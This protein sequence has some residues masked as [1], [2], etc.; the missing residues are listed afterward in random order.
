[1]PDADHP[2]EPIASAPAARGDNSEAPIDVLRVF[3]AIAEHAFFASVI[4]DSEGNFRYVNRYFAEMCGYAPE[5]MIGQSIALVHTP[6]QLAG[7]R[8]IM[9]AAAERGS[10]EPEEHWYLR[11]DGTKFPLLVGCVTVASRDGTATYTAMS[12]F[13]ITPIRRAEMA[14]QTLFDEMLDGFAHHQIICDDAGTPIDYRY[15]AANP[16]FETMT[17]LNAADL[18]GRTVRQALPGTEQ[19]WIENFGRVATTGVPARFEDYSGVLDKHFEVTAFSPAEGEFACIFQ[20]ITERK[21]AEEALRL[22][23]RELLRTQR[24]ARLG[25]WKW[26]SATDE[27]EWT[28]TLYELFGLDPA[29]PPPT[30]AQ[31]KAVFAPASYGA[32]MAAVA[33][34]V[35]T[36][37][38]YEMEV[39]IVR[40]DGEAGWSWVYGERVMDSTGQPTGLWGAA[41]D[42]TERKRE[43]EERVNLEAQLTRSRN[44]E[45]VGT[46][47]GGIAHD[48]NN[49]LTVILGHAERLLAD[50][51]RDDPA[52]AALDE[53]RLATER[54]A[55][56]T[57]QLLAF[58][59]NQPATPRVIDLNAAVD[60][61]LTMLRRLIGEDI[62]LVWKAGA[63]PSFVKVDPSQVDQIL[64]NL[65][66]NSRDAIDGIG[67]ITVEVDE[68]T[69]DDAYCL[70]HPDSRP[71]EYVQLSVTDTGSG[72]DTETL[73]R[74]F[75]PFFTTKEFGRG[76]GLGLATVY[77]IVRQNEGFV[78]VYSEPGAGT[79]FKIYLPRC[80]EA[81]AEI[82]EPAKVPAEG[83]AHETILLVEDEPAILTMAARMLEGRGY[84]V[85]AAGTPSE[86]IALAEAHPDAIDLLLTDV[87]L[88]EMNG[89][90]LADLLRA[91]RPDLPCLFMS[92]YTANVMNGNGLLAEGA[93]FISKPF[94]L[95]DLAAKVRETLDG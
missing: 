74:L 29:S 42:I 39:E 76:T 84:S 11:R 86:A 72:M 26:D 56:L 25:S 58:A 79:T 59:R 57:R 73:G 31:Q 51:G 47:A 70:E 91:S 2:G 32:L 17:G 22:S 14:Y 48:F 69:F 35:E 41:Q 82:E 10:S 23:E 3:M 95:R 28:E 13:D 33:R 62:N 78:N 88:P 36:G 66:V 60:S 53:I 89:R 7:S 75:E 85:L 45:A 34:T 71:G 19:S 46:L 4:A 87:T 30:L 49:M 16:A 20:D 55:S 52:H 12:G 83:R 24:M 64:A 80:R 65:C 50:T 77:G 54:S 68:V 93:P 18:V 38:P 67:T 21:R 5:E 27:V 63:R 90:A 15:L 6:E 92:G 44:L 40:A 61:M 1:M 8:R 43:V 37:E 94:H 9:E 81:S